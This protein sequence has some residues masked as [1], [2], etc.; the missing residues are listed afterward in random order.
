VGQALTNFSKDD[1]LEQM[2][3]SGQQDRPDRDLHENHI[4]RA[5]R[6]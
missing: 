4:F 3:K 6:P 1:K 5:E 2:I